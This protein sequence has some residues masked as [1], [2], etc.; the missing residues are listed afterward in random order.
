MRGGLRGF[1]APARPQRH[2]EMPATVLNSLMTVC[3]RRIP[4]HSGLYVTDDPG[5][6]DES[7]K[8]G[9]LSIRNRVGLGQVAYLH[10]G[11]C[12]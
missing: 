2:K 4:R 5:A 9:N 6:A 3:L 12:P 8:T 7:A 1:E 11:Q 10:H